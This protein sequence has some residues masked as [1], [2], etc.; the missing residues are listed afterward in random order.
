MPYEEVKG[1]FRK[2]KQ[3]AVQA[4]WNVLEQQRDLV[5]D[6]ESCNHVAGN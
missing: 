6:K 2:I 3:K 4:F 1:L 5:T